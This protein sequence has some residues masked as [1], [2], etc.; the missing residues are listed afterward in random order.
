[1][2]KASKKEAFQRVSFCYQLMLYMYVTVYVHMNRVSLTHCHSQKKAKSP[3]FL[4]NECGVGTQKNG[5]WF[6]KPRFR[7]QN[8]SPLWAMDM[9]QMG[10][11]DALKITGLSSQTNHKLMKP[12]HLRQYPNLGQM[13]S[14][15]TR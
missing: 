15:Q 1:M 4:V 9:F 10:A 14:C 13:I 3:T 6:P 12:G 2:S 7:G 5:A 11:L 8:R